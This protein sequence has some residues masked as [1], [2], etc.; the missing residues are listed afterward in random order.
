MAIVVIEEVLMGLEDAKSSLE[1]A[2]T[3]LGWL[4]EDLPLDMGNHLRAALEKLLLSPL[5][6]HVALLDT[7]L[8]DV[9]TQAEVSDGL[10]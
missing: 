8:E 7:L 6:S 3:T 2:M 1:Q 9:A 4:V 10:I 5:Q